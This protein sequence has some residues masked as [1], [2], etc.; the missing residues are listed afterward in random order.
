MKVSIIER[1]DVLTLVNH[2]LFIFQRRANVACA[3]KD[4]VTCNSVMQSKQLERKSCTIVH[5]D[6]ALLTGT[7]LVPI[8]ITEV[9]E[10]YALLI[11]ICSWKFFDLH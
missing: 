2:V 11:N 9:A 8:M 6:D 7:K 4:G 3:W 5:W 10:T 1:S